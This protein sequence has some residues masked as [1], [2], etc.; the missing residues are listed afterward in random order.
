LTSFS[1]IIFTTSLE[2]IPPPFGGYF[3]WED[4][5]APARLHCTGHAN[6]VHS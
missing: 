1:L 4:F 2:L 6:P 3:F 5:S